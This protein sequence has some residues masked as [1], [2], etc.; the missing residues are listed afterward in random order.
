MAR[1]G[2]AER[3]KQRVQA[4]QAA[5]AAGKLD[6]AVSE[7]SAALRS[8]QRLAAPE[9]LQTTLRNNLAGLHHALG[10]RSQARRIYEQALAGAERQHGP[11]SQSV[12]TILNNIAELERSGGEAARAEPLF[13]RAVAIL[14]KQPD[15]AR[16]QLASVLANTAECLRDHGQ[17]DEA[18]ALNSRAL[19]ILESEDTVAHGPIG[20][21]LNNMAQIREQRG[22][23][24]EAEALYERATS[25][26]TQAGA[27]F[28]A[29]RRTALANY[30]AALRKHAAAMEQGIGQGAASTTA[31]D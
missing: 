22:D 6:E 7:W 1:A 2:A 17:L 21:L 15:A 20:V 28:D 14:E 16:T 29:Q 27:P 9:A 4:G 5:L 19:S 12:A 30:A 26:L 24:R 3:L 13:R 8:A 18:S 23:Y 25:L 31:R 10:R 11:E